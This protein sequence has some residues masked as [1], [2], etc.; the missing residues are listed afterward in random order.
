MASP[1][2][3]QLRFP[4]PPAPPPPP[5][6]DRRPRLVPGGNPALQ[7]AG[8]LTNELNVF[9]LSEFLHK[10]L[11]LNTDYYN[12]FVDFFIWLLEC[13][14][15]SFAYVAHFLFLRDVLIRTQRVAVASRRATNLATI[16]LTKPP[17]SLLSHLSP[18][19][20]IIILV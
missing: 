11:A 15:H 4:L 10:T 9:F 14:G 7:Q 17:I 12:F 6:G 13:V 19:Y 2:I 5:Q 20:N 3:A 18:L 16:S 1:F 8:A